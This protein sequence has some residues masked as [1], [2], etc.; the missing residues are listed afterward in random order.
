MSS[1]GEPADAQR[2]SSP[3]RGARNRIFRNESNWGEPGASY[4][5]RFARILALTLAVVVGAL[6]GAVLPTAIANA[7]VVVWGTNGGTEPNYQATVNGDFINAGNGVLQCQSMTASSIGTCND[8]HAAAYTGTGAANNL[9]DN[10]IMGN[11]NAAGGF[12]TNSSSATINIPSGAKVVKAFLNWSANTGTWLGDTRNLCTA[13]SAARGTATLPSGS[14]T[15]YQTQAVQFRVGSGSIAA[16]AADNLREDAATQAT[17]RYYS[18]TADV[19]TAF[20]N[21]A[22][23]SNVT[24][25]A[26]NIWAPTGAGCYAGWS[27]TLVYDYGTYIVGNANSVPHRV[28]YYEGHVREGQNDAALTVDFNGFTAVDKGTRAGF[29]LYEGD[30]GITGDTASYSRAGSTTFTE[31]PNSATLDSS[32]SNAGV[33]GNIGIGRASGS[34]RYYNTGDTSAFTNQSVDVASASLMNVVAGDSKVTLQLGTSGDSYLLTNAVLS[35][36]TAGLQV[37][38]SYNGTDDIQYRTAGEKATFTITITNTGAGVLQNIKVVDDQADCSRTLTGITLAPLAT[39]TYT[40][41]ATNNTAAGYTSTA[42]ATATTVVGGYLAQGADSTTV[43]KSSVALAKTSALAA[44]ATGKAGDVVNYTLTATNDGSGPL[45]GVTITDPLI[46]NLVYGTWSSGT[47]GTLNQGGSVTATGTYVLKQSDVDAGSIANT[48]TTTGTDADGGVKPTATAAR[49][50]PVAA[51]PA[52]TLNKTGALASGAT[53]KVGDT[54]NYSFVVTNTGNV[55]LRNVGVTDP[56]SGL[57]AITFGTWSSGTTG[58]LNPGGSVTGTATYTIKQAD[59]D[60][61]NVPNTATATGTPPTGSAVTA[62]S[63][64]TV[65]VATAAPAIATTKTAAYTT[66]SG[67]VGSVVTYTFTARNSGNVTLTGVAIS[68]PHS[69]LSAL[70]YT[71]PGTAGTLAPGATVTATATYTV[72]QA[73]VDA[74]TITNTATA[75]GTSPTGTAVNATANATIAPQASAPN[76]IFTKT[77]AANG[78]ATGS[79][80]TYTFTLRNSGNVTL[81]G[82]GV[83]DPLSGLSTITYGT[84]PSGTA[85]RLNV[86]D[87]VTGTATYTLKQSDVDAGAVSNTSTATATPPTG[88]AINRTSS[89]TVAVAPTGAIAVTKSGAYLNGGTGKVGDVI[90]WTITFRN[91]GNVTL[92]S[93]ALTDSLSGLGT[94][95]ITWPGTAGTLAPGATATAIADYTVK[96]SDVDTGSVTNTASVTAR[97]PAGAAVS[98]ASPAATVQTVAAASGVT[99]VKT[100]AI[101]GG[102]AG[103]AGNVIT[104]TFTVRNTGNV[105]LTNVAVTDP[106][107]GLGTITYSWPTSTAG[108]LAPGAT[109]T[110][111]A[112]YTIKQSDVDTGNVKNTA[113]VTGTTPTGGTAT[114]T[115]GQV[116]TNTAAA[117][118]AISTTKS[119]A[120]VAGS[121][122]VAGDTVRWTITLVNTG[123]VTLTGV[124]VADSLAGIGALTYTGLGTNSSLAPGAT[125]TAVGTSTLSQADVDAGSVINTATGSGNSPTAVKVSSASTATVVVAPTGSLSITK[126]PSVTSGATAGSTITYTFLVRNTG[127][128]TISTATITDPLS[129]LSA[130]TYSGSRTLAPGATVTGTATYTVKQSDVDA[131]SV[132]NTAGVSGTTPKGVSVTASSGQVTVTTVAAAPAVT[133]TKTAAY[134]SGSGAVNSVI[135]YTFVARNTGNVTL[136][137]VAVSDPHTGLSAITYG[138]WPSGTSGTLAPSTQVTATAT[139]TVTQADV[140]A[141]TVRNTATVAGTPP[142]GAAVTGSSGQVSIATATAAPALTFT[143]TGSTSGATA[144]STVT[145]TFTL[146]NSGN[147]TLTGVSASDPLSGLSAIT[148]GAWPSGTANTLR[149]GDQVTGTATY[150]VKQ[151]DVDAGSISNTATATGTPP[152]GAA[153]TRTSSATVPLAGVGVLQVTKTGALATGATGK[154]GDT[155]T[156]TIVAKNTGNV[157][158]TNVAVTDSLSGLSALTYT[159]PTGQTAGTLAPNQQVTA[160]ATY[161]VTQADVD[162]GT[163]TNTATTTAR[164]PSGGTV[165]GQSTAASVTLAAAAPAITVQKSGVIAGGAAGNAG[166]V[167]NYTFTITNTGNVTLKNVAVTD[168]LSGLS[169]P[170]YTW[171]TSTAGQLAPG[172]VATATATYTIKQS[173]VDNGS[174]ANTASVTGTPPNG[175]AVTSTGSTVT[176]TATAA[177]GVVVTKTGQLATGA[178]GKAG[179]TVNWSFTV[180]NSG[181]VTLTGVVIDD[182]LVDISARTYTW[183]TGQTAGTLAPGQ[184]ATATAT[185]VLKQ[186]DVNGGSVIN[187]ATGAGTTPKS[188]TAT[189]PTVSATVTIQGSASISLSKTPSVASGAKVGDTITYTFV[190]R[191]T[192]NVTLTAVAITDPHAGLSAISYGAWPGGTA[193][194]LAPAEQVTATA[195][196]TVTQD[197]V[198]SGTIN[199]SASVSGTTPKGGTV[200]STA[201]VSVPAT[202][203]AP[204]IDLTKTAAITTG[205]GGVNSV[206]TYTFKL[207]NSGNVTVTGA[208]I[209]DPLPQLSPLAY[210]WPNGPPQ[211]TLNPGDSVTAT[212]TYT[213]VQADVDRGY[214]QNRATGFATPKTTG[215]TEF[216]TQSPQVTT[217]TAASAPRLALTKTGSPSGTTAGSTVT[218]SFTLRNTGNVT[219]TSVGI[220]DPLLGANGVTLSNWSSGTATTL[221]PNDTV[222]GTGTYTVKQSDVDAGSIANTA[223]ATGTPPTG[224]AVTT[225]GSAT[226]PLAAT[227]ALSLTKSAS[228]SSTVKLGDVVTYTFVATNT[229]NVTLSGVTISDP[230]AGLSRV[231]YSTQSRT[232]APGGTVTGTATYTV[233]QAD[234]N[235][236]SIS[237]TAS[238]TGRTPAGQNPTASS[239][240]VT[241]STV[242][243]APSITTTKTASVSDGGV[244]GD[245]VTYTITAQNTGN[246]SLTGVTIS[247]PMF[248]A[249]QID[250]GAWTSGTTGLLQPGQTITATA[251]RTVTQ[252]DVDNGGIT[253]TATSTGTPPT[254]ANVSNSATI[255]TPLTTRTPGITLAQTGA[256]AAGATGK[257]GDTVNWSFTITNS[258][259]TTLTGVQLSGLSV[260]TGIVYGTWPGGTANVLAPGQSVTATGTSALTQAQVDARSVTDD[261]TVTGTAPAGVTPATVSASKPATVALT[262][263]ST[264]SIVKTGTAP[265]NAAVGDKITYGFTLRNTGATTL[266][267]VAVSDP[268]L[269]STPITYTG[270]GTGAS[271]APGASATASASYTITQ[272]DIDAGTVTNTA[273]VNAI[274][275]QGTAVTGTSNSVTVATGQQAGAISIAKSASPA[276]GVARGGTITYTFTVKNTGNVTLTGVKVTDPMFPGASDISYGTWPGGVTGTLAPG[277]TVTATAS[278]VVT[279]AEFDAGR[280]DNQATA[281]GSTPTNATVT[282]QSATVSTT[283]AA[284]NPSLSFS[285]SGTPTTGLKLD[286]TVVWNFAFTNTGDVTLSSV[287]IADQLAVTGLTYTGLG[288]GSSLAPGASGT[289]TA[290]YKV[291]QADVDAGSIVNTA[292]ITANPARGAQ[293]TRTATATVATSAQPSIGL[294]KTAAIDGGRPGNVGDTITYTFTA[295]NTGNQ[296]ITGVVIDDPLARLGTISYGTWPTSTAGTLPPN[297]SVVATAKY[298]IAQS[299]IDN[300]SIVNT[301][302]VTGSASGTPVKATAG[303]VTTSVAPAAPALTATKAANVTSG[304]KVGDVIRY[305]VVLANTGNQTL[306][307]VTAVDPHTGLGAITYTWPGQAGVLAPGESATARANYTVTQADVDAGSIANTAHGE[308]LSP[309]NTPVN[310]NN[311][312]LTITTDPQRA[313]IAI[314]DSGALPAGSGGK[315]DDIVTWTYVVTN[316][317][318]VTLS[319]VGVTESQTNATAPVYAWPGATGVLAPGE[320]VRV[321]TT[322]KLTQADVD[323]GKVTS[324][325]ATVGTPQVGAKP[326]ANATADVMVASNPNYTIIKRAEF[327]NGGVGNVG[328]TIRYYLDVANTG[329]VTLKNGRLIDHLPG[330]GEQFP[331]WPDNTKPGVIPPGTGA[332]GYADYTVTQADVDRGSITN[333]AGVGF[334]PPTGA[335]ITKPSNTVVTPLAQAAPV[336]SITETGVPDSPANAGKNVTWTVTVTNNGN[337]TV[338]NVVV[339]DPALN[340]PVL[341]WGAN[342]AG[343]LAPG[344]SVTLT[345]TTVI[346]QADVDAGQATNSSSAQGASARDGS[347]V[348]PVTAN[349]A[350]PTATAGPSIAIQKTATKGAGFADKAGDTENLS[351]LVTNNGNQTL[352]GVGIVDTLGGENLVITFGAWPGGTAGTLAP[353]ATVTATATHRIIQTEVDAGR[354]ESPATTTGTSTRGTKV[355]STSTAGIDIAS[356]PAMTLV[357][358]GTVGGS[359]GVNAPISYGFTITNTGNVSLSLIALVDSLPGVSAPS[360]KWPDPVEPGVLQPGEVATA[361]STYSITQADVDA[362]SVTNTATA[363]GK[364]PIGDTIFVSSGQVVT[365]VAAPAPSI[366]VT[367]TATPTTGV[368]VGDQVTFTV[369]GTN[370]GNVTLG[371]VTL[372]DSLG[373]LGTPVPTWP[374]QQ[375]T[376]AVGQTVTWQ[377]PYTVTQADVDAG[378]IQNIA[379]VSGT[380]PKGVAVSRDATATVTP[381]VAGPKIGVTDQG[382][383]APGATGVAGDKVTWSYV[384]A[385]TGDVTLTGITATESQTNATAVTYGTWPAATGVL[386]PGQ[387]VTATSS[388]TL[389]QADVNRGTVSSGVSTRGTGP[390]PASTVVTA[391]APATVSIQARPSF[392][393]LKSARFLNGGTGQVGDTI[394][395]KLTV[396]NTGNVTLYRAQLIDPL[397]GL[398]TQNPTWPDPDQPGVIQPGQTATGVANYVVTQADVDAGSKSNIATARFYFTPIG[399]ATDPHLDVPSNEVVTPLAQSRPSLA[400]TETGSV[401]Q[402]G[403]VGKTVTWTITVTNN[404]NVTV[405]DV[406][407]TPASTAGL[408]DVTTSWGGNAA[409]TLAPGTSLTVTGTTVLTQSDVD[410][411][412]ASRTSQASGASARD[413]SAVGPVN[414]GATVPTV[415]SGPGIAVTKSAALAPGATGKVDDLVNF[416]YTLTNNG[417]VT[418]TQSALADALGLTGAI[419]Y[420]WKGNPAGT[421]PVGTT[422][423]ATGTYRL[424]QPDVDRGSIS[425]AVTGTGTAPNG[426]KVTDTDTAGVTITAAPKLVVTKNGTVRGGGAGAANGVIDY[427]FTIKNDGNVTLT[428][429]DLVDSLGGVS[430]PVISWPSSGPAGTLVPGA[431]AT[432]TADYTITQADIDKGSVANV[433]TST[434]KPPV[435]DKISQSSNTS[436][437]TVGGANTAPKITVTETPTP[438]SGL[439]VGDAVNFAITITNSGTITV[440]DTTLATTLPGMTVSA[441]SWPGAAGVLAPGQVARATGTYVVTQSDVDAGSISDTASSTAAGVRGGNAPP[442]SASATATTVTA[443]PAITATDEGR[444]APGSTGVAGDDIQWLYRA[445][446]T[447]NTTLTGVTFAEGLSG[448]AAP[449]VTE[450]PDPAKPGVLLPGQTAIAIGDYTLTQADVDSGTIRSTL[451]VSGISSSPGA[452]KV[453]DAATANVPIEARRALSA[454]KSG[455]LVSG[456]GAVGDT[457][458]YTVDITN[459]GNVTLYQGTLLDPLPGLQTPTITWPDPDQPGTVPPG[460]VVHGEADYA[461]TQADVDRGYIDNTAHVAA[462]STKTG[463]AD[464]DKA[465]A[466]TNTVR[467]TTEQ[468]APQLAVT[469]SASVSGAGKVGDTLTYTIT[470]KN[471]GNVTVTGFT[472]TDPLPRLSGVTTTGLAADGSLAPGATATSKA[473]YVLDQ[474]DIDTGSVTNRATAAGTSARDGSPVSAQSNQLVTPTPTVTA[475]PGIR[476]TDAGSLNAPDQNKAGGAATWTYVITNSG[477]V[478][479]TGVKVADTLPIGAPVYAWTGPVG[480]LAPGA[481]VTVTAPYSLSQSD[482][483]AGGPISQVTAT[484]TPKVGANA[485][486]QATATIPVTANPTITVGQTAQLDKPGQNGL[487]NQIDYGFTITNTGNTTLTGVTLGNT[488]A[489]LTVPAYVWPDPANPGVLKPGQTATATATHQI[490]QADV[491]A[492]KVDNLTTVTGATPGGATVTNQSAPT[493]IPTAAPAPALSLVKGGAMQSGAGNAGSI[494]RFTFTLKNTGNVTLSGLAVQEQLQGAGVPTMTFPTGQPVLAP[495]ASATGYSDYTLTQADVDKGSVAN[496]A[497]ASGTAAPNGAPVSTTSNTF[498][499]DTAT[500]R[501]RISTTQTG[502][503]ESGQTGELG[504]TVDYTFVITNTG[505]TSLS[506]VD[507]ANT[508][509]GLRDAQ[510]TWP[511]GQTAGTLAPGQSVTIT[512]KHDVTQADVDAGVVRNVATGSGTDPKGNKVSDAAPEV[513]LPLATA[514]TELDLTKVGTP[515]QDARVGDTIDYAFTLTNNGT[516]TLHDASI[517]DGLPG[518]STLTYGAWPSGTSG[519]LR[520]GDNV[521]ASATYVVTQADVDRGNVRNTASASALDPSN[522]RLSATSPVSVVNTPPAEP[523]ISIVKTAALAPGSTGRAGDIVNYTFTVKNEGNVTLENVT[524]GDPQPDLGNWKYTWP[525]TP[526]VLKPGEIATI[527]AEHTLTQPE[528][529]KGVLNTTAQTNGEGMNGGAPVSANDAAPVEIAAAPALTLTKTATPRSATPTFGTVID[530]AF[531]VENTGN[532]TLESVSVTD[533]LLAGAAISYGWPGT[534][535]RL[536]PGE[537]A[538]GTASYTVTQADVDAGSVANT[539]TATGTPPL[540]GTKPT[541][542]GSA[543]VAVPS[544]S[545]VTLTQS[546]RLANGAAGYAGDTLIYTYVIT[547][548]GTTTLRGIVLTDPKKGLGAFSYGPWPGGAGTEG[549][550]EPGQSV[551]VTAPYVIQPGDEGT[552]V[553]GTSTVTAVGP[554]PDEQVSSAS[555][556]DIQLPTRPTVPGIPGLPGSGGLAHTGID[557]TYPG[558]LALL[559]LLWGG[560]LVGWNVRRRRKENA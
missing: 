133:V 414:A 245:R 340:N 513:V 380:S 530:Y 486:A 44:G 162:A 279:Q 89:A 325:V 24:L 253:N 427:A 59:V 539:A 373:G 99:V 307:G 310:S 78:Q 387:S 525:G 555:S 474:A 258:G 274:N 219:L 10:A 453:T 286:D 478:T 22:T 170:I 174:V 357:K 214:V 473:T 485:T 501:P 320:S 96:Q 43:A 367:Q 446:N 77:G 150:T 130:I 75:A 212:A 430:N 73:D 412:A 526:G 304:A 242:V 269:G 102:A 208:R 105:T 160:T 172:A 63:S 313:T 240:T 537:K 422:V 107:A 466:A 424:T 104:Y 25:S 447:G 124:S 492:G 265:A 471:T 542:S 371:S 433:A 139:Y 20:A 377:I 129:G 484:G 499:I 42:T 514:T 322:Y 442:A 273:T 224:A 472:V 72:T 404:G 92:S 463:Q 545:A 71:W 41:T 266:T 60:R 200:S 314:T 476:V 176:N 440:T 213:I 166:N 261:A 192:G 308:S 524:V 454:V 523:G 515:R 53:G 334:T 319:S 56:L 48:A 283:T 198:N 14:A 207:T 49:T 435:G 540:G 475:K 181:N 306:H 529:D 117:A 305:R 228:P 113:T 409:G 468:A 194:V 147:V 260:A 502:A 225:Q 29:T 423:T 54:I 378:A 140:D 167:I 169:A 264:I 256:L 332:T 151:S 328:D 333:T 68:D 191:N 397:P 384:I 494:V 183:P 386:A 285:K 221:R 168:P 407:L 479:L 132:K 388:Y 297:T 290:N 416:S 197:D 355:T 282:G 159:W 210:Q 203:A 120:L 276:S 38:K 122:G 86:G 19:T 148:Y 401:P 426:A 330:L 487:G 235:R 445:K 277:A 202:P 480:V 80:V 469:K 395:Y 173:D 390:A 500:S 551:T 250:Y 348:G 351:Y 331:S 193:N 419:A 350:A 244:V 353:G 429:V 295:S 554:D 201:A 175:A 83:T 50:Q 321:T 216:S 128:V 153:I 359:G 47:S 238:V 382:A 134:T 184:T 179:D 294:T 231:D 374:G 356:K 37:N 550:L 52:L 344:T 82:V 111:T 233:T 316:T 234:V 199:N 223:T 249:A 335:E 243:A 1:W 9:N 259:N 110:G 84:W 271:L 309:A 372:A 97:T 420:D 318:N 354:S 410:A 520:P 405:N 558:L 385:N 65:A 18:A 293:L 436:N 455:S 496:T 456:L 152:T 303:P 2:Q 100:G 548:T 543:T 247:D 507:V 136:T 30:R 544:G 541:A 281:T 137:G 64:R 381:T 101:A 511:V 91:S 534:N 15:G 432:A 121:T 326:T 23:G 360:F 516:Q 503:F 217:P 127:N 146:R 459:T 125:A 74:G 509:T 495:G 218:Y 255:T 431:T 185:Y 32:G 5:S 312:S 119:G 547:N 141:G 376:L 383:L 93:V 51:T 467:V 131:G 418:L 510:Y 190:A 263:A 329:N 362:G 69:G 98:G 363:S 364:P 337:V 434:A 45:T 517:V 62:T 393:N 287:Q 317:G 116:T 209:A 546:V 288:A 164:T 490:S 215:G 268:R 154:V 67:A 33:T 368:K 211:G 248:T 291:T 342:T 394:E 413:G 518:V 527:T 85:G 449:I 292:T 389:T 204:A 451:T 531:V 462:W 536:L 252:S 361:T 262:P 205:S 301:A 272:A 21:V 460:E 251:V 143:K 415:G 338:N 40:C 532:V 55:T 196:Y 230:L 339:T 448:S 535:G 278:H 324:N 549:V 311:S 90:R 109:A 323:A 482:V 402:P 349:A 441:I 114:N 411:G 155:I 504:D 222:S 229:G 270:L 375:R 39:T 138:T 6:S 560:A 163:V 254:G 421:V 481:S 488:V 66:G 157:T 369:T 477:E 227:G 506:G 165:T 498:T 11:V 450:W 103:N 28:I 189:S 493:S 237:N 491:D 457:V 186:S 177:P 437:V 408:A 465:E 70:T 145:Y 27:V 7:V 178:T 370:N 3:R 552:L 81:T 195:S 289:A 299:D 239:P 236:G 519:V 365:A 87:Q 206:I 16:Y 533:P 8:L 31:I 156:W 425:S 188:G 57:S 241:T 461:L 17:A 392:T 489:G 158:L 26:G 521:T 46:T 345:G 284:A 34:Q 347:A 108:T 483:D 106:L 180:R 95:T 399:S 135:T 398:G 341:N 267:G 275:P 296:T 142:T 417:N 161:T 300:Q 470:T 379:T 126:T 315:A 458:R 443:G 505:N 13:Y 406:A 327:R 396:T 522:G 538:T 557:P 352:S 428:L 559:L 400:I 12:T 464:A 4:F 182:P 226:V 112:S 61:G 358:K 556:A 220:S 439:R 246:V 298:T 36:P 444:L 497:T 438:A 171:P 257:A 79:V 115:S 149:V 512:A 118:P 302:T 452:Q 508:V 528:V 553:P 35:V 346:T 232:L 76:L 403:T 144:G 58:Q 88:A 366:S 280:V 94:P 187:T 343:S 391:T 336:L 123:N